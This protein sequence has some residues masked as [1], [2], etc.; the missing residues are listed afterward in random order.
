MHDE[1]LAPGPSG[2]SD[3]KLAPGRDVKGHPLLQCQCR[4]RLAQEGLRRVRDAGAEALDRLAAPAAQVIL[5]VDEQRCAE[6]SC[7]L[8][9]VNPA[10]GEVPVSS[11]RRGVGEQSAVDRPFR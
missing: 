9:E 2:E 6:L 7:E 3:G 4:H 10:D 8:E 5:V 1:A 11:H